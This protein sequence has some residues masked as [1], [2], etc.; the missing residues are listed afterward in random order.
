MAREFARIWIG[1]ADDE[2][3]EDLSMAAQWLYFRVLVPD[4]TLNHC[5]VAD[6]RPAR[7]ISKARDLTVEQIL[8]AAGE[9][10]RKRYALFD[11]DTEEVLVRSYIRGEKLLRN[12]KMA[13]AVVKSYRAVASKTLRAGV[14]SELQ[15]EHADNP[16]YSSWTY[17]GA[18]PDL[19]RIL[20]RP[21]LDEVGYTNRIGN[22]VGVPIGNRDVVQIGNRIGNADPVGMTD[23]QGAVIGHPIRSTFPAPAPTDRR[24]QTESGYVSTEGHQASGG[25]P[26]SQ[27]CSKHPEGTTA[28]C[29]ACGDARTARKRWDEAQARAAAEA[30]RAEREA[31]AEAR[32]REIE[33]CGMCDADGYRNGRPCD[34]N[35]DQ[36]AV[37]ARGRE[38]AW[39]ALGKAATA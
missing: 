13:A 25:E 30:A 26:P 22:A 31:E 38:K 16:Q 35:P 23:T 7:L 32:R 39:A 8:S 20:S 11:L 24:L 15:R 28:P 18:G 34:H 6:W 21:G 14:V 1:I 17:P 12:P 37:N 19:A 4:P 9:L 3:L 33:A 2:D 29:R 5:G 27:N 36:D 10:E